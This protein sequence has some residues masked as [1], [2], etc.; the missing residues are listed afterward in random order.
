MRTQK[1]FVWVLFIDM[2][3]YSYWFSYRL[4]SI[5]CTKWFWLQD[6]KETQPHNTC[7][8]EREKV[9]ILF[10]PPRGLSSEEST[11]QCRRHWFDPW[12]GKI[13]WT[14]KWQPAS[15]RLPGESHGQ[16][17]LEGSSLK[18]FTKELNTTEPLNNN[19]SLLVCCGYS[20]LI[21]HQNSTDVI[22]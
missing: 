21:P 22:S 4:Y 17:S 16:R 7:S 9:I 6:M 1:V 14:R 11:C 2:H 18:Q 3:I 13:S 19:Y 20:S 5:C 15:V 8:W 10:W 12:V